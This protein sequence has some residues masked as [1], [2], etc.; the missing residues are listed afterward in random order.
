MLAQ[1]PG[2]YLKTFPYVVT[3]LALILSSKSSQAPKA[4][5]EPY[6]KGKR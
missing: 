5:G 2:L 3:L 1:I 4:I 6:D